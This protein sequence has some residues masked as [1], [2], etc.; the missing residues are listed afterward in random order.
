MRD[1]PS[2]EAMNALTQIALEVRYGKLTSKDAAVRALDLA[3]RTTTSWTQTC[4]WAFA[5]AVV[6]VG[7]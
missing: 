5:K 2:A 1:V 3:N 7:K 6:E 4:T